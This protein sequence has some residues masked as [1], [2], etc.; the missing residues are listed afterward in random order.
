MRIWHCAVWDF[1]VLITS[2][3]ETLDEWQAEKLAKFISY[4][5][6]KH[7]VHV[8]SRNEFPVTHSRDFLMFHVIRCMWYFL[9]WIFE[10]EQTEIIMGPNS[11]F[12]WYMYTPLHDYK[13]S[14]TLTD[15]FIRKYLSHMEWCI[16]AWISLWPL[17]LCKPIKV[18]NGRLHIDKCNQPFWALLLGLDNPY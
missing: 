17:F 15:T 16:S 9:N 10:M 2:R 18:C 12:D 1:K 3:P 13:G 7:R 4:K 8:L 11:S 14:G 5:P 6:C